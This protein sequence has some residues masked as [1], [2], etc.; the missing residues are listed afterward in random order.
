MGLRIGRAKAR[1]APWAAGAAPE[2][3]QEQVLDIDATIVV[4]HSEDKEGTAPTW[5][6][7]FGSHPLYC[8]LELPEVSSGEALSGLLRP[9]NAGSNTAEGH[10][11]VLSLAL[12]SL[13]AYARPTSFEAGPAYLVRTGSAGAT[14]DFANECRAEH[15]RFSFGSPVDERVRAALSMVPEE[16]W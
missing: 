4:P 2:L 12:Q 5:E 6:H 9:G 11:E 16:A 7:T 1:E 14:H 13:P 10:K 3:S 8:F 15:V